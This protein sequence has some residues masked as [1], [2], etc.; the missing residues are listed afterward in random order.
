MPLVPFTDIFPHLVS[1]P[2][3][4]IAFS[5]TVSLNMECLLSLPLPFLILKFLKKYSAIVCKLSF[6]FSSPNVLLQLDLHGA[7]WGQ[8]LY[9]WS[10]CA[11]AYVGGHSWCTLCPS[12]CIMAGGMHYWFILLL[13]MVTLISWLRQGL[14][15]DFTIKLWFFP[16]QLIKLWFALW[17]SNYIYFRLIVLLHFFTFFLC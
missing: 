11:L 14:L 13:I 12:R 9:H 10:W 7:F 15:G 16:S 2:K 6:N 4:L 17:D 1:N 8:H 3:L 5:C